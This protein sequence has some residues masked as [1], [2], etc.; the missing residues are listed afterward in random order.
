MFLGRIALAKVVDANLGQ[1]LND[2]NLN[3]SNVFTAT[4]KLVQKAPTAAPSTLILQDIAGQTVEIINTN[5]MPLMVGE[6]VIVVQGPDERWFTL[7]KPLPKI[8]FVTT[9]KIVDRAVQV[10]VLRAMNAPPNIDNPGRVLEYGD[11]LTIYD[12]FNKWSDIEADATGWAYLAHQ[13]VDDIDTSEINEAHVARYEIEECSLPINE[14]FA[15]LKDCLM[16]GMSDGTALV[17]LEPQNIRSAY[18]NVDRPPEIDYPEEGETE[19]ELLFENSFKLDG[20]AGSGCVLRRLT[21]LLESDPENYTAPTARSSTQARWEVVSVTKKIAR[22]VKV[23]YGSNWYVDNS[24]SGSGEGNQEGGPWYDGFDPTTSGGPSGSS[25][26]N[27]TITCPLCRCPDTRNLNGDDGFAFLDTT[28]STIQYIVYVTNSGFYPAP[29]RHKILAMVQ[30]PNQTGTPDPLIQVSGET[31][32]IEYKEVFAELL[33]SESS[34]PPPAPIP[35]VT[36]EVVACDNTSFA[37]RSCTDE[38]EWDWSEN[39]VDWRKQTDCA[40]PE[41]CTCEKPDIPFPLPADGDP[42]PNTDC[43]GPAELC[44]SLGT[45]MI[46]H[47]G[48]TQP[49]ETG[50]C[51]E[52]CIPLEEGGGGHAHECPDPCSTTGESDGGSGG[53]GSP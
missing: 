22:H 43:T 47:I 12:P 35:T 50:L 7:Q 34:E 1:S 6:Q 44:L 36:S 26:C 25:N 45:S 38:C 3:E 16:G 14:I 24:G 40:D 8:Q 28:A 20:I 49:T 52:L 19:V 37:I 21:N 23:K 31:C 33:C 17:Q 9:G 32:A 5:H 13:Q 53:T 46:R 39:A 18:P 4:L 29:Q 48:C 51:T 2:Q 42:G 30:T 11:T 15:T 10:K 27:I 41:T